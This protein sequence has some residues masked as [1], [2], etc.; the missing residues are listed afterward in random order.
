MSV[1]TV[2]ERRT[3]IAADIA[4]RTGIDQVMIERLVHGFYDKVRK[5]ALLG[6]LFDKRVVDWEMHL[7]RMCAFWSSVAL[8]SGCYHG[9][10]MARHLELPVD[11]RHFDRWLELFRHT[12]REV[13]PSAAASHFVERAARIAESLELGI[14][15][16]NGIL[17]LKGERLK[18]PD[19]EVDLGASTADTRRL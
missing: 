14:A 12:A 2:S 11:S 5:D 19:T 8:M 13:C 17:V 7:Q 10:P 16:R 1:M 15:G 3:Q 9:Q 6:P 18:R 4:E